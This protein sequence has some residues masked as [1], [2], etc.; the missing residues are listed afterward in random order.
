MGEQLRSSNFGIVLPLG[1]PHVTELNVALLNLAADGTMNRL[2]AK[3]IG[4]SPCEAAA[5]AAA[6]VRSV[7]ELENVS[8]VFATLGIISAVAV[9]LVALKY[10]VIATV[11]AGRAGGRGPLRG[12][13]WAVD[14]AI[15]ALRRARGVRQPA[16]AD[17]KNGR[18][19][20]AVL[21]DAVVGDIDALD[22]SG[23]A[24]GRR[25]SAHG[26]ALRASPAAGV[27][28][29]GAGELGGGARTVQMTTLNPMGPRK[30]IGDA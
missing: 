26:F 28:D 6:D 15:G 4:T 22:A 11:L 9:A 5:A 18:K 13:V 27:A 30:N 29:W 21:V 23:R 16:A 25:V 17:A 14:E 8:G 3:Y 12:L 1:F 24:A 20:S 2:Y 19:I 10:S 7:T